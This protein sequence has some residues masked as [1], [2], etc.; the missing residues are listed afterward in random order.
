[1]VGPTFHKVLSTE[2]FQFTEVP[3]ANPRRGGED[4]GP[5]Q[6][7]K[8]ER[9]T[10]CKKVAKAPAQARVPSWGLHSTQKINPVGTS[11]ALNV[12][13]GAVYETSSKGLEKTK[14]TTLSLYLW[15]R[16]PFSGAM[17]PF[18]L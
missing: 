16:W 2:G 1:M 10:S 9:H 11:K 12:Q 3:E 14:T 18:F 8:E 15:G 5:L 6:E 13:E 17:S 4:S 7:G